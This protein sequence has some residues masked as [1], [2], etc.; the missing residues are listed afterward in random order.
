MSSDHTE[1]SGILLRGD[2]YHSPKSQPRVRLQHET[3]TKH[4]VYKESL[5]DIKC[6]GKNKQTNKQQKP[7]PKNQEMLNLL[8]I[9]PGQSVTTQI[10]APLRF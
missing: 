3:V 1:F 7:K 9:R 4:L 8:N 5:L 2:I 10:Q 6:P